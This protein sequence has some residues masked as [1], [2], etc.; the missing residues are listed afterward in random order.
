M[1][2]IVFTVVAATAAGLLAGGTLRGFPSAKIRAGWL[3][4]VG[5]VLQ[6]VP[7]GGRPRLGPALHV[8]RRAD[9]LRRPQYPDARVR[10]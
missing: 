8:V 1:R 2:L 9:R 7:V 10:V 3:A 6:F 5:V 4:L